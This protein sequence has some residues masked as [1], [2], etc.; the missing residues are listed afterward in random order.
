MLKAEVHQLK[1]KASNKKVSSINFFLNSKEFHNDLKKFN[2]IAM[3]IGY[4]IIMDIIFQEFPEVYLDVSEN[5]YY[6]KEA[7]GEEMAKM[8]HL[9]SSSQTASILLDSNGVLCSKKYETLAFI[10]KA[11]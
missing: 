3:K 10:R 8:D 1:A 7:I 9:F 11:G 2:T 4:A 5:P 6:N